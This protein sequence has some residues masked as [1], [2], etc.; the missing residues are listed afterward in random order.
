LLP[1]PLWFDRLDDRPE[2]RP[3][4]RL[5]ERLLLDRTLRLRLLRSDDDRTDRPLDRL[6]PRERTERPV[7]RLP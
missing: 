5:D 6:L 4:E 2:E 1:R 7:D 3:V